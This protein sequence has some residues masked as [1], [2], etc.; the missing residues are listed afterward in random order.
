MRLAP[1]TAALIAASSQAI[2]ALANDLPVPPLPPWYPLKGWEISSV[3]TSHPHES[4]YGT[5]ASS[6]VVTISNPG[7]IPAVPAPHASGGGYVVFRKSAAVCELHWRADALTPYGYSTN[8]CVSDALPDDYSNARWGVTLNELHTDLAAPGDYYFSLAFSLSYNA[9]IY[10]TRGYK[11]M[12]AGTF[13]QT[14]KNLQGQCVDG[15]RCDYSLL[16]ESAPVRL[17]PT[18]QECKSACG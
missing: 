3:T 2:L 8:S 17:Q 6:L 10:A 1:F 5:N 4:P 16:P 14:G 9:S 12:T 7:Q 13:F 15:G 11:Y 18:L